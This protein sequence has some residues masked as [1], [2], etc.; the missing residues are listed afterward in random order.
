MEIKTQY[1][2]DN[3][4]FDAHYVEDDPEKNLKGI[5]L[6]GVHCLC[7]YGDKMVIV[8]NGK[9]KWTPPGGAI[10]SGESYL[11]ASERETK[12]ESNMKVLYQEYIGYQDVTWPENA[13][14]QAR[15]FAVVEPYGDFVSDPDGDIV[16]IKLIDPKEFNDYCGWGV[17]GERL[18]ERAI[19]L[20]N[21]YGT[22][23]SLG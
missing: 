13:V 14:R 22:R 19:E 8:K 17:I 12:E 20:N 18:V 2:I 10:E 3:K 11:Q 4:I 21:K 6:H 16:E 5:V 1:S 23:K 15:T 9:G 7:F